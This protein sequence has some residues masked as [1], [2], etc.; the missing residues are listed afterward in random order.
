MQFKLALFA[1]LGAAFA[2]KELFLTHL[3]HVH[4][5]LD[6]LDGDVKALTAGADVASAA[7]LLTGKSGAVQAA[8]N[9]AIAAVTSSAQLDLI[10]A[11]AIVAPADHLV[12]ETQTIIKDLIS[13]KD[14]IV[15]SKQTGTVL[16]QLKAQAVSA[17]KLADAITS[18]V[19][20]AAKAIAQGQSSKI[21]A[22]IQSGI[23]AFS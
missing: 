12:Q 17:Q 9:E 20:D 7:K 1:L 2:Q 10:G 6:A 23:A 18:K 21:I 16:D 4:H 11:S 3:E 5:A 13:K 14:I 8:L 15:S 19:P 22:A